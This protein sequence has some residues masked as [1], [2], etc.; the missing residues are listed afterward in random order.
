MVPETPEAR[1][2]LEARLRERANSIGDQSVRRHYMQ[3]FDE[4]LA[5]FFQPI[6]QPARFDG[7]RGATTAGTGPP[8][9]W[10]AAADAGH[11][12]GS[13]CP[14]RCAIRGC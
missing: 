6:R 13:W 4:R 10:S 7:G 8:G 3:A 5:A 9:L 11:A 1:A 2:A 12:R 14:I